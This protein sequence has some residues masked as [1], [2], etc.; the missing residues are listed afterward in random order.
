MK[1]KIDA[2]GIKSDYCGF[3]NIPSDHC[4]ATYFISE[5]RFDGDDLCAR[6]YEYSAQVIFFYKSYQSEEDRAMEEAFEESV[7]E[8]TPF[9]KQCGFDAENAQFYSVYKFGFTE[10]FQ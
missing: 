10:F 6:Y 8:Y 1:S 4:Y 2:L 9:T 3:I 7:R 5:V